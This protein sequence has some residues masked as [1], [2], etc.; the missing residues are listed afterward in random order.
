MTDR[1]KKLELPYQTAKA[2]LSA[3]EGDVRRASRDRLGKLK[4]LPA[5]ERL[6]H[7]GDPVL[8]PEDR[9]ALQRSV[10][11]A[12]PKPRARPFGRR[13]LLVFIRRQ[14]RWQAVLAKIPATTIILIVC[15][16]ALMGWLNT[17]EPVEFDRPVTAEWT[18][19]SGAVGRYLVP[20]NTRIVMVRHLG[21]G[22]FYRKWYMRKGYAT[23][24][25]D[26][27]EVQR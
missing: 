4:K 5:R 8:T 11:A 15:A 12:L 20:A 25:A 1:R 22:S 7:I 10:T 14:F 18:F 3:A 19:P 23:A 13:P 17:G 2:R 6:A 26:S 16:W 27:V 9:S 21:L 24:R